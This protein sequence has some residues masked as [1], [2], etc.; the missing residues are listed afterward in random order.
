VPAP[1]RAGRALRLVV[2]THRAG[3]LRISVVAGGQFSARTV[4]ITT[5]GRLVVK[6][7]LRLGSRHSASATIHATLTTWAGATSVARQ[8]LTLTR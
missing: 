4:R 8:H 3:R 5:P 2:R 7:P 6:L 1:Q